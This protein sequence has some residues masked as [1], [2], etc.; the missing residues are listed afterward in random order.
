MRAPKDAR[1]CNRRPRS[2]CV[3]VSTGG[4]SVSGIAG[5]N[6]GAGSISGCG[7]SG[8]S[9]ASV[10][11]ALSLAAR[12]CNRRPHPMSVTAS[13]G[14]ASVSGIAGSSDGAGSKRGCG[15]GGISRGRVSWAHYSYTY[16]E[17]SKFI[18]GFKAVVS[19][20]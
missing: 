20:L 7:P 14:G 19:F 15:P 10:S 1:I 12:I 2:R 9:R 6:D 5:S 13:T 4:A 8:I 17:K 16:T 18:F 11:R 3:T